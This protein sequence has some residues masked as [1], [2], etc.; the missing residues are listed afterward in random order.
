M[1]GIACGLIIGACAVL[2]APPSPW[3]LVIA[4]PA[5]LAIILLTP[6]W[7]PGLA[8][9]L[10][11]GLAAVALQACLSQRLD[12]ALAGADLVVRGT[13]AGLPERDDR[14]LRFEFLADHARLEGREVALPSRLRLGWY[15]TGAPSLRPGERWRLTVRLRA[16]RGF[17]NPG[18]FDYAGWLL[19]H[20]IGA[21][22]YVRP[23]P[24]ARRLETA[25]VSVDGLRAGLRDALRPALAGREHPGV[26][27]ALTL[28]DR[29]GIGPRAWETLVATG[30]NHLMAI[31]GLH[32]GLVALLGYGIGG[33]AWRPGAI[34]RRLPRP[35]VQAAVALVLATGYAA[36]A[37]FALPTMRALAMLFIALGA[38]CLRRR[39]RPASVL[40]GAAAVVLAADPLA[41]LDP[42]FWLSFGAVAAIVLVAAGR[43][44]RPRRV[45]GWLRL[46]LAISLALAPL[47]LGLF[48]QASVVAPLA[49]LVAVPWVSLLTVPAALAGAA[50]TPAWP[51]AG[52]VLLA[53]ADL[54]LQVLWPLLDWLAGLPLARWRTP[55][56]PGP[57]LAVAAVGAA[58]LLL[59]RGVPGRVTASLALLPLLLWQPPR[60]AAGEVWL[61]LL[62]VGQGLAAVVRTREH[63]LVYDTGPRFSARFDAGGAVINPFL[64]AAGV[65][66]LDGL[67]VS[68]TDNDHAGGARSLRRR[69]PPRRSWSSTPQRTPAPDR[70]CGRGEAWRWDAVAF[71]FLHPDRDGGWT[72]NDGSCVLRI[73]AAGG[74]IL[75]PGD[76]ERPAEQHLVESGA[77]L[78]A[79]VVVA[80][81]H[82]SA[83]SSTPAFVQ[84]VDP[85]WVLYAVGHRN[86]WGF[87]RPEIVARWRPAGWART[88]CGGALHLR[89]DRRRG[90]LPP[91][92]WRIVSPSK[93]SAGCA[94]SGK[95]GNMRAFEM[96]AA[97]PSR[98]AS[99]AAP[100][101]P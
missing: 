96:P 76:I 31:S 18:G 7:R 56:F 29:A 3:L 6:W 72:G 53:L 98:T 77:R 93:W 9:L 57:L 4:L 100:G 60:P 44:G 49:N 28:G 41:V 42:G 8:A 75:L 79:D 63:T 83:T 15:G 2:L 94:G 16:P 74:S 34:R 43:L 89:V 91:R 92:A 59:P 69:F 30:T 88:D 73:D 20:G 32:I 25:P 23:E 51:A 70:F 19:R 26:L 99:P 17:A 90:V 97:A 71:T 86:Q 35:V 61:D 80:P 21:T 87:P 66:R 1:P 14:R 5:A 62:D 81:H 38:L 13:V 101:T 78:A 22:G 39:V 46:Q 54:G 27:L 82:G 55:D 65:T 64:Q 40:G 12:P 37:G 48:R 45:H 85:A 52:A 36:L 33:L 68:H 67:V 10:G 58:V 24:A 95:S 47:L 11:L 50:V 84:A